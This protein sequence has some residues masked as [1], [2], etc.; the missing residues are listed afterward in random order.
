M[1]GTAIPGQIR[2]SQAHEF[3][4][5]WQ[6]PTPVIAVKCYRYM[7]EICIVIT[8]RAQKATAGFNLWKLKL[9]RRDEKE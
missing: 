7:I 3:L 4:I 8:E 5:V 1:P 9:H 6:A 2:Q